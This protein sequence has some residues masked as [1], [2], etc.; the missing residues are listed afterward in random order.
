MVPYRI[1]S[2]VVDDGFPLGALIEEL[3]VD[4]VLTRWGPDGS[5]IE[6]STGR[7]V[8]LPVEELDAAAQLLDLR[9]QI[10]A[11]LDALGGG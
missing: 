6:Q 1:E 5:I 7:D 10:D 11:L 4:G 8:A 3:S 2:G 9:A